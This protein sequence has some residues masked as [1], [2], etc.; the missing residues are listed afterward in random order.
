MIISELYS[1]GCPDGARLS[2]EPTIE[3]AHYRL[4]RAIPYLK[5][6][7]SYSLLDKCFFNNL[8][9]FLVNLGLEINSAIEISDRVTIG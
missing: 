2:E 8:S 6:I 3:E 1:A 4:E 5:H 9:N 7:N